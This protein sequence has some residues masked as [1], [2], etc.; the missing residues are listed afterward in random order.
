M[1]KRKVSQYVL[2][3]FFI[4]MCVSF[5]LP[6]VLLLSISFTSD[7][8]IMTSGYHFIPKE[9]SFEGYQYLWNIRGRIIKAVGITLF[10]TAVGTTVNLTISSLLAYSMSKKDNKF[11]NFLGIF[12][13]I[14]ILFNGGLTPTYYLYTHIFHLKNT[15]WAYLVPGMLCSGFYVLMMRSYFQQNISE[16]ICEAAR[17]DGASELTIFTRIVMPLSKPI[18]ATVGIMVSI[19][20]SNDWYLGQIYIS[21]R[22]LYS[23][24]TLLNTILTSI[25]SLRA[26]VN[27]DIGSS[28][29]SL[30]LEA[31]RMGM[32]VIGILPVLIVYISFQGYFVKGITLGG[33]KG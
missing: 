19:A 30:P 10:N 8:A 25:Q 12:L 7:N 13:V 26:D 6:L 24:Q 28:L 31:A 23:L 2:N 22:D 21:N 29:S 9:F 27:V 32:A 17:I 16:E 33:V 14:T 15:L 5:I 1:S 11:R 3:I 4:L 20:F 18:F